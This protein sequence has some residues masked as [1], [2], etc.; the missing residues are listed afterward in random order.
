MFLKELQGL[1]LIKF[2]VALFQESVL[3]CGACGK[4]LISCG[5]CSGIGFHVALVENRYF[6]VAL[7]AKSVL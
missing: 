1:V 4:S 5:A 7:V 2:H 3:S 6:H